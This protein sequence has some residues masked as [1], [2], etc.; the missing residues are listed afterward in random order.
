MHPVIILLCLIVSLAALVRMAMVNPRRRRLLGRPPFEGE[1]HDWVMS[2][3]LIAP[4]LGLISFGDGAGFTIWLGA[5]TVLGW[6]I[7]ANDF[8]RFAPSANRMFERGLATYRGIPIVGRNLIRDVKSVRLLIRDLR[9][10]ADRIAAL[11]AR[12]LKLESELTQRTSGLG[13]GK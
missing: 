6:V 2:G 3:A 13:E 12:V 4:G 10:A 8:D 11:E 9:D 7:V 5:L 1:R